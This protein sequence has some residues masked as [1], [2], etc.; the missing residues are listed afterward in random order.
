MSDQRSAASPE[1]STYTVHIDADKS[2]LRLD[3]ALALALPALSRRQVQELI[4][5]GR[6]QPGT[7]SAERLAADRRVRAGEAFTVSVPPP[8]SPELAP[9]PLPLTIVYDDDAVLVIDK[10]AGLVVHPGA[11]TPTGTL[12][13]ALLAFSPGRL[14][15]VGAPLRPGIV[16]RLDKETSGLIVVARTDAAHHHLAQ[17]FARHSIERLYFAVVWGVPS[18]PTG[19]VEGSIGRSPANR[20]RM[21]IVARGGKRAITRYR[22]RETF[23]RARP[24]PTPLPMAALVECR[25]ETGR[26]HQ[27]RVH[28]A[29]LGHPLI[30]DRT[31]AGR[32]Q[33]GK[34]ADPMTARLAAFPRH[35]L[36][37]AELAFDHPTTGER[38]LFRSPL[39][40]DL[41]ALLENLKSF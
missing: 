26:T 34:E 25:P 2:G 8:P 29:S 28:L 27:I 1:A 39:P 40:A 18:P 38:L 33:R 5:A 7:G 35:A 31:Y 6:V 21:A 13:H 17:Q 15:Q 36:H 11:G 23:A 22:V 30:G 12:V 3:R 4:V 41:R 9:Q 10:P 32:R 20:K 14:S 24:A 37:A 16:H 19:V